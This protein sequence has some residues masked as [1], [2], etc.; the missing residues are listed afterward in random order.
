MPTRWASST[1]SSAWLAPSRNEK[2]DL[3]HSGAYT[4]TSVQCTWEICQP[5]PESKYLA[6]DLNGTYRLETAAK[7]P[8]WQA[9]EIVSRSVSSPSLVQV[10][11]RGHRGVDGIMRLIELA[12]HD[13]AFE[14]TLTAMCDEL[15]AIAEVDIASVYVRED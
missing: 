6:A 5:N 10:H 1:S 8:I 9:V 12:S 7:Y 13:G 11:H 4:C 2:F 14:T 15:T 3:H